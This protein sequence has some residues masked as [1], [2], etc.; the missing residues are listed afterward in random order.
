M[1][2][3]SCK[4]SVPEIEHDLPRHVKLLH[5][6]IA[7]VHDVEVAG[8]VHGQVPGIVEAAVLLTGLGFGIGIWLAPNPP[9]LQRMHVKDLH[10]VV[11][12]V[13]HVERIRRAED[14]AAREAE[15]ARQFPLSS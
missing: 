2:D 9:Q 15:L 5:A 14:Q 10:A 3:G 11:A 8:P 13:D 1:P 7:V 6:V 4:T 12:T